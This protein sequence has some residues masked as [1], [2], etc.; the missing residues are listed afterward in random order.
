[1]GPSSRHL[2]FLSYAERYAVAGIPV[3]RPRECQP[4]YPW[5]VAWREDDTSAAT[6]DFLLVA[7]QLAASAGWLE[8]SAHAPPWLP[9]D[10]PARAEALSEE[11]E[12]S[13]PS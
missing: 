7:L 1:L 8:L 9:A 6:A 11:R 10:E 12:T 4:Y 2:E 13:A 5:S 3:H